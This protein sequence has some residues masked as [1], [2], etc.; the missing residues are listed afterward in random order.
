MKELQSYISERLSISRT[1]GSDVP[2]DKESFEYI[3]YLFKPFEK[4]FFC[5]NETED[6]IAFLKPLTKKA[7]DSISKYTGYKFCE[8]TDYDYI[9]ID[10]N[11]DDGKWYGILEYNYEKDNAWDKIDDFL[12]IND[13]LLDL[14]QQ[15]KEKL[16]F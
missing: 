3:Q 4:D 14:L 11:A 2:E 1:I 13:D 9:F 10:K 5:G 12:G 7:H 8:D 15:F 16:G 6:G